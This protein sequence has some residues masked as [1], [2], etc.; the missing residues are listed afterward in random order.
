M[1]AEEYLKQIGQLDALINSKLSILISLE[2]TATKTTGSMSGTVVSSSRNVHSMQDV[3]SKIMD[4]REE[5][6]ADTD[7]LVDLR[8]EVSTQIR[9]L[10]DADCQTVLELRYVWLKPWKEISEALHCHVRSVYRIR[11]RGLETI[12]PLLR[13][14]GVKSCHQRS[15]EGNG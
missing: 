13:D 9:K 6:N 15:L 8:N 7:R 1:T 11:D 5:V 3:I 2:A 10:D 14:M 4:L 12:A